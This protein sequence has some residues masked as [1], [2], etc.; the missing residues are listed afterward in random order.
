[1]SLPGWDSTA[2]ARLAGESVAPAVFF[3]LDAGAAGP[4]RYWLGDFEFPFTADGVVEVANCTYSGLGEI[5]QDLPALG[6]LLN[7]QAEKLEFTLNGVAAE[8]LALALADKDTIPGAA[9][10]IG[11]CMLDADLQACTPVAWV[12]ALEAQTVRVGRPR[13]DD[14]PT[15]TVSLVA[16]TVFSIRQQSQ[17]SYYTPQDQKRRSSD[18][19]FCDRKP[20]I[21]R[22]KTR[23]FGPSDA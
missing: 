13:A 6:Q 1:M 15:R 3:R 17:V 7:G 2:K 8:V 23:K 4:L 10:N 22:G 18:D 9:I 19:T 12:A 16:T 5:V 21:T 11:F 14:D 20:L